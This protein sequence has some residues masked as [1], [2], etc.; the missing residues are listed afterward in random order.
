MSIKQL[1]ALFGA[2]IKFV[3]ELSSNAFSIYAVVA[4]GNPVPLFDVV[5]S[6][7]TGEVKICFPDTVEVEIDVK[8]K[9]KS[10]ITD[11]GVTSRPSSD[12]VKQ[13]IYPRII[14]LLADKMTA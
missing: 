13:I 2:T 5:V 4:V 6:N 1:E 3:P 11:N 8:A 7:L 9:L 12:S 10:D 14:R